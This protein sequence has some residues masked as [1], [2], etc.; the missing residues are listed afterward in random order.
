MLLV[1]LNDENCAFALSSKPTEPD[2][3][4]SASSDP[5]KRV[6]SGEPEGT[7]AGSSVALSDSGPDLATVPKRSKTSSSETLPSSHSKSNTHQ[8][9]TGNNSNSELG[10]LRNTLSLLL[11]RLFALSGCTPDDAV[12]QRNICF[13]LNRL[14]LNASTS[15]HVIDLLLKDQRYD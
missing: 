13:L 4:A 15:K 14:L 6:N 9:G 7:A 3:S 12:L 11:S 10:P 8:K 2:S 5:S 1:I